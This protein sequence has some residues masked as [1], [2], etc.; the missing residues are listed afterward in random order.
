MKLSA[1]TIELPNGEKLLGAV[2][3]ETGDTY[4]LSPY[5][6]DT[7]GMVRIEEDMKNEWVRRTWLFRL[8]GMWRMSILLCRFW[9]GEWDD[10]EIDV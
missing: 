9:L 4:T 7:K 2:D 5:E 8:F 3:M 6:I 1:I 10:E